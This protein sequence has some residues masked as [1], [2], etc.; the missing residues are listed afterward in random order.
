[1]DAQLQN[2]ILV[3]LDRCQFL[4]SRILK[5]DFQALKNSASA[6]EEAQS[7]LLKAGFQPTPVFSDDEL[8]EEQDNEVM[9]R[10]EVEEAKPRHMGQDRVEAD[11]V[12]MQGRALDSRE[13]TL[14]DVMAFVVRC[15]TLIDNYMQQSFPNNAREVLTVKKGSRYFRIFKGGSAYAFIDRFNGDVLKPATYK[16]PARH[17]RGNIFD[18][19][20]GMKFMGPYGPAYLR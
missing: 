8:A 11:K 20:Q 3:C 9:N 7:L 2:D 12:E 14:E 1:M 18:E 19:N 6:V 10:L 16:A 17:S 5:A 13:A 15:Q 4:F